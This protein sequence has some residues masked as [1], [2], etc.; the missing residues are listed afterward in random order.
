MTC[1]AGWLVGNHVII[2]ERSSTGIIYMEVLVFEVLWAG[3]DAEYS[4]DY[5]S[6]SLSVS[7]SPSSS[8]SSSES[9]S[10]EGSSD[11]NIT[12]DLRQV[13]RSPVS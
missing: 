8:V 4:I 13:I 12:N 3:S 10:V 5:G 1:K 6:L 7:L 2:G 9:S 11:G